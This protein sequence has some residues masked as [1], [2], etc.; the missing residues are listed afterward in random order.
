[1]VSW[2]SYGQGPEQL[3]RREFSFTLENDTYIRYKAFGDAI[4]LRD[5]IIKEQPHKIDIGAIFTVSPEDKAKVRDTEFQPS[6]RELVFDID[7]TDYDDVRT[8]CKGATICKRCWYFMIAAAK[9]M[10][11]ALRDDF[12]FRH[13]LWVYSGRRGI[14]CWVADES[15]RSLSNEA[16]NAIIHYF[17]IIEV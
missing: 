1:M 7:L 2:L 12:N 17:N 14:H 13:I 5:S 15:A 10:D 4:E 6:E 16:R 8:C 9:V 11:K 3:R